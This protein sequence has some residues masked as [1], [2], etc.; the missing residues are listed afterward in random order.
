[1]EKTSEKKVHSIRSRSSSVPIQALEVNSAFL[2]NQREEFTFNKRHHS[3]KSTP[4]FGPVEEA[5]MNPA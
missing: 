1:M 4:K 3:E 2:P 5:D